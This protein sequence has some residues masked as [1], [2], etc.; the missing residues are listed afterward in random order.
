MNPEESPFSHNQFLAS[1]GIYVF[2]TRVLVDLLRRSEH[3]DFGKEVIPSSLGRYRLLAHP[4]FGYWR[5]IGTIP[6][7]F[8]ANLEL[9]RPDP[10]FPLYVPRWPFYT[11]PRFLAPSRIVRSEI[12]DS[13]IADGADVSGAAISDSIL[14]MRGIVRENTRLKEVVFLG[15]DFYGGE[16]VLTPSERPGKDDPSLGIGKGCSIERAIIDKNARIGDGVI[17]RSRP[18]VRDFRSDNCW[19]REGIT[20]IP[21]GA[22]IPPGTEL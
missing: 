9:T 18:E 15:S 22:V 12:R 8:Q 17:I 20:V 3:A 19:V 7:F 5:D 10:P 21:K 16:R 6:A 13:L 2:E 11:R 14:G 4:F 1:M